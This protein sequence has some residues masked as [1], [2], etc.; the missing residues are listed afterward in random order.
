MAERDG[1]LRSPMVLRC[2]D[3]Y[4]GEVRHSLDLVTHL[5]AA[6][7]AAAAALKQNARR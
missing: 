1:D 7:P 3:D 5:D 2:L 4:L 6:L